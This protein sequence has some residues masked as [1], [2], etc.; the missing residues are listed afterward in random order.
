[1]LFIITNS[2]LTNDCYDSLT[3]PLDIVSIVISKKSQQ[4]SHLFFQLSIG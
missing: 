2:T 4:V 3:I 1:M